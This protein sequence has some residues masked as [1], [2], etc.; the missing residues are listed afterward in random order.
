MEI[1]ALLIHLPSDRTSTCLGGRPLSA[2][3]PRNTL[4]RTPTRHIFTLRRRKSYISQLATRHS[5]ANKPE[6]SR[7]APKKIVSP[8]DSWVWRR[9]K[10]SSYKTTCIGTLLRVS[11]MPRQQDHNAFDLE[12]I[13]EEMPYWGSLTHARSARF[14]F[15]CHANSLSE[16]AVGPAGVDRH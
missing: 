13:C 10:K 16:T 9:R 1:L 4:S 8:V 5:A 7:R 11:F 6:R 12:F 15:C 3:T 2:L 14:G